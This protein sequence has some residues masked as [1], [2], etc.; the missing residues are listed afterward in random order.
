MF[1]LVQAPRPHPAEVFPERPPPPPSIPRMDFRLEPLVDAMHRNHSVRACACACLCVCV[2]VC[3][4]AG[5]L[6]IGQPHT[7]GGWAHGSESAL[8]NSKKGS[9]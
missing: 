2:C 7:V 5:C 3:V 8:G 4:H 9:G 1:E 6:W